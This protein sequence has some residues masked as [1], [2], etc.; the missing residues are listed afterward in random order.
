L[1]VRKIP[2]S[3]INLLVEEGPE[4]GIIHIRNSTKEVNAQSKG[5]NWGNNKLKKIKNW[6][7]DNSFGHQISKP[8]HQIWE[9]LSLF[10]E[11]LIKPNNPAKVWNNVDMDMNI[12]VESIA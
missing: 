3:L 6:D 2:K 11:G 8:I 12:G 1:E 9:V 7:Q 10:Q 5:P 4:R